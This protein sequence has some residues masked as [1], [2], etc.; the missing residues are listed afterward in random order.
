MRSFLINIWE[1]WKSLKQNTTLI[2]HNCEFCPRLFWGCRPHEA[3]SCPRDHRRE[4]KGALLSFGKG[5]EE[6]RRPPRLQP[7]LINWKRR[8]SIVS[9][10]WWKQYVLW[11]S[12]CLLPVSPPVA[13]SSFQS[14]AFY[15]GANC[16]QAVEWENWGSARHLQTRLRAERKTRVELDFCELQF[17]CQNLPSQWRRTFLKKAKDS[18][19]Q[20]KWRPEGLCG[21]HLTLKEASDLINF[22]HFDNFHSLP[23]AL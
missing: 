21:L 9:L 8:P 10:I 11:S 3:C 23:N 16:I 13:F 22:W 4:K 1:D 12:S 19:G 14:A 7:N 17:W 15:P 6:S 2:R 5:G 20:S 18:V